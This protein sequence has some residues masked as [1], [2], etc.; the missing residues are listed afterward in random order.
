MDSLRTQWQENRKSSVWS[1][2]C[3]QCKVPRKVPYKPSPSLKH[4]AQVG[5]TAVVFTM[6]TWNWFTWKGIV[7]FLPIWVVFETVYRSKLRAA[8]GCEA[9]GFDPILYLVDVKRARREIEE[10]W[11]KKFQE[12]GI[13]YPQDSVDSANLV[14][15]P[16]SSAPGV[17]VQAR[18]KP[19]GK[20]D[21]TSQ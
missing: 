11:K 18:Q 3:P 19:R 17:T 10:H 7:A 5:L 6:A 21:F 1:F 16:S 15:S 14:D 20:T 2:Y 8:L 9:C 4:Y 13:P 12:K